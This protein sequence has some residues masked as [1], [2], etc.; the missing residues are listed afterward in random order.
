MIEGVV[1]KKLK[2]VPDERGFL[3]EMMRS[4]DPHF[5]KFGQAYLSVGYPGVI[6]GWHYHKK[7]KDNFFI[8][9]GTAKVVL[10]DMREKSG[11]RGEI[12][13]F[14]IGERNPLMVHIPANVAH[15]F[16]AV[17]DETAYLINIPTELYNY[18][19]PDEHRIDPHGGEI[20]YDWACKDS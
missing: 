14:F 3:M 11:T 1:T 12:N 15:G 17:G 9:R 16:K 8:V 10:Y 20:P 2:V 4:D 19:Q 5:E 7:Q 6:K 18:E 13:E